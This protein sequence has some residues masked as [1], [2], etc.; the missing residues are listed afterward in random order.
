MIALAST[1]DLSGVVIIPFPAGVAK[2][3]ETCLL[4]QLPV[5]Q[6]PSAFG[7]G[8]LLRGGV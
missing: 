4:I 7:S 6:L 2:D 1:F 5:G 3:R 8:A